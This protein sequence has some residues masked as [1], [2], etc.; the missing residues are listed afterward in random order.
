[1]RSQ[2]SNAGQWSTPDAYAG[3]VHDPISQKP[4]MY[5]NNNPLEY[6]DPSGYDALID[7]QPKA[8]GGAGHIQVIIYDPKTNKGTSLS[9]ESGNGSGF[10]AP[11]KVL[12]SP[13]SN[14]RALPTAQDRYYHISTTPKQNGQ[15]KAVYDQ[16]RAGS[17][18]GEKYNILDN[19]CET[20]LQSALQAGSTGVLLD[21]IPTYN[22]L[23]LPIQGVK[24]ITPKA[25][26]GK[27]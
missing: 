19:N 26:P 8:V 22:L 12:E 6:E 4:Y 1:M 10:H 21:A 20:T 27:N 2:D 14:V 9:V 23:V 18:K 7:I 16:Q 17:A 5:N 3:D 25:L 15:I 24:Q 11:L 13:V